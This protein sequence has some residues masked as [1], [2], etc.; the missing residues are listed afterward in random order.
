MDNVFPVRDHGELLA[1]HILDVSLNTFDAMGALTNLTFPAD[2]NVEGVAL[3]VGTGATENL[4]DIFETGT[5]LG[6]FL[7][8]SIDLE[9][10]NDFFLTPGRYALSFASGCNVG[11]LDVEGFIF[12]TFDIVAST[13]RSLLVALAAEIAAVKA[14]TD[15]IP[16]V[17]ARGFK[18]NT[19]FANFLFDMVESADGITPA[20]GLTVT[21][22]RRIDNGAW[23]NCT[24][25]VVETG[26]GGY[27]IDLAAADLNGVREVSL[28]FE[29]TGA[30]TRFVYLLLT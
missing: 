1:D 16:A 9:G 14:K 7:K 5:P 4:F 23:A 22:Q 28:K 21:A 25:A 26:L 27:R 8:A 13:E 10:H 2:P 30:V 18:A 17:P 15:L 11:G 19:A 12:A 24:N 29:A 20:V 3:R 6:G